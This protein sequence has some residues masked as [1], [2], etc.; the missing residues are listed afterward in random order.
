M[1][2]PRPCN[3]DMPGDH[4]QSCDRRSYAGNDRATS[5]ILY[6][7]LTECYA[8][9]KARVTQGGFVA[10]LLR[11][12]RCGFDAEELLLRQNRFKG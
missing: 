3:S 1:G 10:V 7:A 8:D 9:C 11:F 5:C 6:I 2:L 12:F 4:Q